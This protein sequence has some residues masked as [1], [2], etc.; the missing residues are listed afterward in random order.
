MKINYAPQLDASFPN[1][2][3]IDQAPNFD[4]F[5]RKSGYWEGAIDFEPKLK[6]LMEAESHVPYKATDGQSVY[7]VQNPALLSYQSWLGV[8]RVTRNKP[9]SIGRL[10][11]IAENVRTTKKS[12]NWIGGP[13]I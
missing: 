5:L 9:E 10:S 4:F 12:T 13:N 8:K 7:R 3:R 11:G 1:I 6:A 2:K